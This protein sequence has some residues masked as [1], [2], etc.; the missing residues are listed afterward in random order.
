M[1]KI[2]VLMLGT[3]LLAGVG[4]AM[5]F[6]PTA[7]TYYGFKNAAG[8]AKWSLTIPALT[9]CQINIVA[10][11]C[12]IESN[13]PQATVLALTNAYPATYSNPINIGRIYR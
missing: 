11:A 10:K 8:Q 3:A 1:K 7:T 4:G 2:K 12:S 13:E 9:S 5:A 6:K